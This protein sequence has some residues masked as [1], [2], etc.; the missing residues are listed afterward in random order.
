MALPKPPEFLLS[1][2]CCR[3]NGNASRLEMLDN[4][5]RVPVCK[6]CDIVLQFPKAVMLENLGKALDLLYGDIMTCK[7]VMAKVRGEIWG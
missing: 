6:S 3:C 5:T 1:L 4:Q 7:A 2:N